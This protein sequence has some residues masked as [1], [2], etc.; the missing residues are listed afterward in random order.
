MESLGREERGG[1]RGENGSVLMLQVLPNLIIWEQWFELDS[2]RQWQCV[3]SHNTKGCM[4]PARVHK[5]G[6][7]E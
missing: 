7:L 3:S 2:G 5:N 4:A 1:R 6:R